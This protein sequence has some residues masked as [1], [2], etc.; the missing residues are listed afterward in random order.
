MSFRVAIIGP[1][2][3]G[4][5]LGSVLEAGDGHVRYVGREGTRSSKPAP[6]VVLVCVKAYDTREAL[7]GARP[8]LAG[9]EA[10]VVS[11]QNGLGNV[12][13]IAE[14]VGPERAFGGATTHAARRTGTGELVHAATGET[15]IAPRVRSRQ[16]HAEEVARGLSS[17]GLATRAE[18]DLEALLW[19]KVVVSCGINAVTA[20][21]GV[22]NGALAGDG[23]PREL[24]R[25]AAAEALAVARAEGV[26]LE[27]AAVDLVLEVAARTAGNRSSMLQDLEFG[28]RTE[29]DSIQGAVCAR[30]LRRG[31][32]TPINW[33]LARL[34]R[35]LEAKRRTKET[36]G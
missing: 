6:D 31:V 34:V 12:E 14:M 8:L 13:A 5:A 17:H 7:E 24:A 35:A 16:G 9:C 32:E 1:G 22:E 28:R 10:P 29:V 4:R 18:A 19:R 11:L 25:A 3:L 33:T 2:A 36:D 15:V 27:G 30:G 21:L 23:D 26:E 20:I